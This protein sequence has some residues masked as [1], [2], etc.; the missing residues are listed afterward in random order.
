[1]ADPTVNYKFKDLK[2]YGSNEWLANDE[3]KYRLVYDETEC[4]FIYCELSFYNKLFD[5]KDWEIKVNL[6][7]Y[8]QKSKEICNLKVDRKISKDENVVF[9][10][11]GWGV[12]NAGG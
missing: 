3:K 4:T 7:C 5:E 10:R 9:I 1:M 11:E 6:K 2:A 8:D 12:K